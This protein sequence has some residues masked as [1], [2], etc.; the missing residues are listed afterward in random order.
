VIIL[1]VMGM[2]MC[3]S[4]CSRSRHYKAAELLAAYSGRKSVSFALGFDHVAVCGIDRRKIRLSDAHS[5]D[6]ATA[7]INVAISI[8]AKSE[9]V[10]DIA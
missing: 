5:Y 7:R 2:S 1:P 10:S 9:N 8:V 6:L 4:D 3:K